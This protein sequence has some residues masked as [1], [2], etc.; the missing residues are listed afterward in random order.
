MQLEKHRDEMAEFRELLG[1][2]KK[3][4]ILLRRTAVRKETEVK[5]CIAKLF[6]ATPVK[7]RNINS[8]IA[9]E[10]IGLSKSGQK[11]AKIYILSEYQNK[12][13]EL[14]ACT[15]HTPQGFKKTNH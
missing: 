12:S 5:V 15:A 3:E 9:E 2:S 4:V 10:N 1:D 8:G 13:I 6:N 7:V 11:L 14:L